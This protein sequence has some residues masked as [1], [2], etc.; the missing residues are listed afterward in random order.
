MTGE[1]IAACSLRLL[2]QELRLNYPRRQQYRRLSH[3]GAA[4]AG[5][6]IAA[7]LAFVA[8]SVLGRRALG[9]VAGAGHT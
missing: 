6:A 9:E 7:M 3:G 4:M 2:F 1:N 5:S 8:A